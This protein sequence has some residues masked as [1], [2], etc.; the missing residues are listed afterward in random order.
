MENA[1]VDPED[2]RLGS[3]NCTRMR[4]VSIC[5][6]SKTVY[7]TRQQ[8]DLR[9]K[10]PGGDYALLTAFGQGVTACICRST[11]RPLCELGLAPACE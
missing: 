8:I 5:P 4:S 10:A 3:G 9:Q 2:N 11:S 1:N 6:K 7:L